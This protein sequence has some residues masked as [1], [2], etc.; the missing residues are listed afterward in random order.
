M[1]VPVLN[2]TGRHAATAQACSTSGVATADLVQAI[3]GD[4][5]GSL[6]ERET[7]FVAVDHV[8]DVTIFERQFGA[9][10]KPT[11]LANR[12]GIVVQ[13]PD[14]AARHPLA[15]DHPHSLPDAVLVT[16]DS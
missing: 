6:R 13:H 12:V 8:D 16:F 10:P 7:D 4:R 3:P 1:H 15:N 2:Q 14:I 9:T 5:H 11:V